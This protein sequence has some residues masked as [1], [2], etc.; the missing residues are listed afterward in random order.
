MA[1]KSGVSV[2]SGTG[3]LAWLYPNRTA[4]AGAGRNSTP[5][6]YTH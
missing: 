2:S 1:G 6:A 3:E 4:Q 5:T